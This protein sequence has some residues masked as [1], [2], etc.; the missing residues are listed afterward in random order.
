MKYREVDT[1]WARR[2]RISNQDLTRP[3]D[4]GLDA[5]TH[6]RWRSLRETLAEARSL[7]ASDPERAAV[8]SCTRVG[9]GAVSPHPRILVPI[10]YPLTTS[11]THALE[12]AGQI[13][14]ERDAKEMVVLYVD[15]LPHTRSP[16]RGDIYRA[17]A[18]AIPDQPM[19]LSISRNFLVEEAIRDEAQ[20]IHADIIVLEK[21]QNPAWRRVLNRVVGTGLDIG[22]FLCAHTDAEIIVVE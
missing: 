21:T 8:A 22:P 10:R 17:I 14:D 2:W 7:V 1:Q 9:G 18:P 6:G 4:D 19:S 3:L 11:S 15:R 20:S 13:A 16:P 12:C 5:L